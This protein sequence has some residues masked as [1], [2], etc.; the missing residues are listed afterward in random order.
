M[1]FSQST[2]WLMCL[3]VETLINVHHKDWLIYSGGTDRSGELCYS[4]SISNDLTQMVNFPTRIP[5]CDS[6][7]SAL[8][9]LFLSSD[10][11]ICSTKAF[12]PLQNSDH[13]VVSVSID[14]P[15]YSQQDAL[16]HRI[17]YSCADWDGLLDHLRYVSWEDI[18]KFSASAAASEFCEWIQVG[19]D[20][21]IPHRKYQVKPHSSPWFS[22]GCH[23]S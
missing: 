12:P 23:S 2:H 20:V 11:S 21:Y 9:G 19:I 16:F 15:S 18:F 13:V 5:D 3:S 17:A 8:L 1:R 14:F 6:H 10:A 22:A 4:F 7:S